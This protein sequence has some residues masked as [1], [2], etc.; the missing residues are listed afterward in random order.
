MSQ[1]T[2][3]ADGFFFHRSKRLPKIANAPFPPLHQTTA[4]IKARINVYRTIRAAETPC[5]SHSE[6]FVLKR[7]DTKS[8]L[9]MCVSL[10]AKMEE[11]QSAVTS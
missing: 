11:T 2:L 6:R 5:S 7:S 4:Y 1:D 9:S 10:P 8:E 3:R